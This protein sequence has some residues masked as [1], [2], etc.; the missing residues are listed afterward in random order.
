MFCLHPSLYLLV[1]W[2]WWDWPLMWLTNHRP[3]VLWHCW[4]C[5]LTCKVVYEMTYNV[6]SATLNSTVPLYTI[7]WTYDNI[8]AQLWPD[9]INCRWVDVLK[10]VVMMVLPKQPAAPSR[11]LSSSVQPT[12][13]DHSSS[14]TVIEWIYFKTAAYFSH[15]LQSHDFVHF[16]EQIQIKLTEHGLQ[17]V[18]GRW[19]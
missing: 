6:L 18:E 12:S 14:D 10:S 7:L 19:Q 17:N 13:A 15:F 1:S 5:H 2:A 11:N 4:L 9:R 3:S 16:L 8:G